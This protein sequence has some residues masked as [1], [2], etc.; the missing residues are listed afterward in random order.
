MLE[1]PRFISKTWGVVSEDGL[2]LARRI[3]W[4]WWVSNFAYLVW[5][6]FSVNFTVGGY[7]WLVWPPIIDSFER[8][9][10]LLRLGTRSKKCKT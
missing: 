5:K 3:Q 7:I 9:N 4:K 8:L 1:I 6:L 2:V 10:G